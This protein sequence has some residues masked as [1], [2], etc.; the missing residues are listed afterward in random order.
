MQKRASK[1]NAV[2]TTCR[3]TPTQQERP[4]ADRIKR[5]SA[6]K[7]QGIWVNNM[8]QEHVLIAEVAHSTPGCISKSIA[9][10]L[11]LPKWK[12]VKMVPDS[13][14]YK[15]SARGNLRNSDACKE[16]NSSQWKWGTSKTGFL[17]RWWTPLPQRCLRLSWTSPEQPAV[18]GPALRC[19]ECTWLH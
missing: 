16:K 1:A 10:R 19:F 18:I 6:E 17:D 15:Q 7:D 4:D 11:K 12:S 8:N 3:A 14:V 13:E 5:S 9:A 2:S